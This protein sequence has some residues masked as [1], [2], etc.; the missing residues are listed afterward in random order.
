[1]IHGMSHVIHGMNHVM[2]N[3]DSCDVLTLIVHQNTIDKVVFNITVC[4]IRYAIEIDNTILIA[5][6]V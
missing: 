6:T 2:V 5:M 4:E 3:V 1:M